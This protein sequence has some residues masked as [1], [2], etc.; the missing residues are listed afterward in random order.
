MRVEREMRYTYSAT[1]GVPTICIVRFMQYDV[2]PLISTLYLLGV[3]P[4]LLR[5]AVPKS[6]LHSQYN[7]AW[8]TGPFVLCQNAIGTVPNPSAVYQTRRFLLESTT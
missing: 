5:A 8:P 2:D 1:H 6:L 3:E 7:R 4:R